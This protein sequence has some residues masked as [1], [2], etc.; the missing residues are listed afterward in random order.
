MSEKPIDNKRRNLIKG[1]VLGASAAALGFPSIYI[2]KASAAA[3]WMRKK[4]D[5]IKVGLLWS[6][7]GNL[8]VIE[9]DSTQVALYAIDEINANGG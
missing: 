9:N 8:A 7:T 2:P 6:K 1:S 4:D 3:P 5:T